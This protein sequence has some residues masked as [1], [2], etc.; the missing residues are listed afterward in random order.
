MSPL[1]LNWRSYFACISSLFTPFCLVVACSFHV[2]EAHCHCIYV[3]VW[4]LLQMSSD[5]FADW[6]EIWMLVRSVDDCSSDHHNPS[7]FRIQTAMSAHK[8]MPD[9]G[10]FGSSVNRDS[11]A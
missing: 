10:E 4:Q 5:W 3:R 11:S 2:G 7:R 8:A 1:S 6:T 9:A